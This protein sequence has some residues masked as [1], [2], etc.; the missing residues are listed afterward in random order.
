[1]NRYLRRRD[2]K[3]IEFV[4]K[5]KDRVVNRIVNT[6]KRFIIFLTLQTYTKRIENLLS[7]AFL[8]D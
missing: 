5:N 4:I 3:V 6:N 2:P 1:M 8:K 7:K